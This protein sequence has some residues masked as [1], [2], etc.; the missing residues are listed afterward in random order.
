MDDRGFITVRPNTRMSIVNFRAQGDD[1]DR[2]I[3][4]LLQGSFRSITGWIGKF[5]P[6]AYQI[7]TP[8]ATIGVRG[9]DHEPLV[10]PLVASEGEPG[11]YDNVNAG[12]SYIQTSHGQFEVATGKAAFLRRTHPNPGRKRLVFCLKCHIFSGL[13]V[14]S[15]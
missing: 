2:S 10:I 6:G 15:I 7:R 8:T 5:R 14:M 13:P 9:T 3:L 12:G 4:S 11:T 1:N